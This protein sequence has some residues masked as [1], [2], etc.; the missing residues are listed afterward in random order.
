MFC[1]HLVNV[2]IC[3]HKKHLPSVHRVDEWSKVSTLG[4]AGLLVRQDLLLGRALQHFVRGGVG[5][6]SGVCVADADIKDHAP[7][8]FPEAVHKDVSL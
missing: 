4:E 7:G 8:A 2:T 5:V 1:D 6:R 3:D